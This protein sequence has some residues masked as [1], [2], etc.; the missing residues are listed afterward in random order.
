MFYGTKKEKFLISSQFKRNLKW[1]WNKPS[2]L[3][4]KKNFL[5]KNKINLQ[6]EFGKLKPTTKQRSVLLKNFN[7]VFSILEI[8]AF[9][10]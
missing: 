2:N 9:F 1:D 6:I 10:A 8:A 4:Q 3:Q 5:H 7:S